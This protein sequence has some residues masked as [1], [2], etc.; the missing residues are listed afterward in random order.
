MASAESEHASVSLHAE[1]VGGINRTDVTFEQGVTVLVGRNATH[2]TSLLQ[3][4]MAGLGS[5]RASLKG[6]ADEGHVRLEVGDDIYTRTLKRQDGGTAF[7]DDPYL[8]DPELAD[9]FAFLLESNDA[10]RTVAL[11]GDLREII[12]EPVD[13]EAIEREIDRL[14]AE[15]RDTEERIAD[16]ESLQSELPSLE[17]EHSRLESKI[18]ETRERL[19]EKRDSLDE[20][21][22]DASDIEAE[23]SELE[24]KMADLRDR[25]SSLEQTEFRLDSQR[26]S[27][28]TLEAELADLQDQREDFSGAGGED[29]AAIRSEIDSLQERKRRLDSE[30]TKLQSVIQFNEEMMEGTSPD[31]ATALRGKESGAESVTDQLLET[32]ESVVCWTCGSEVEGEHIEQTLDRLRDLRESKYSEQSEVES[33]LE[34]LKARKSDVESEKRERERLEGKIDDVHSEIEEREGKIADLEAE[35]AE[36]RAAIEDLEAE[37]GNIEVPD[38]SDVLEAHKEVNELEIELDRLEDERD[39]VASNVEEIES[40]TGEIDE[41]EEHKAELQSRLTD[42]RTRI[43]QIEEQAVAEFNDHMETVLEILDYRNIDRIWVERAERE[44]RQ[45]RR[46]VEETTFDLHVVRSTGDGVTYEDSFG[47]LSESEREVTGLIFALAGYLAHEV[48]EEVP[49]MLLDSLEAIDSTRI[50]K[51]VEYM[52]EYVDYLVVALLPEDA[53][54]LNDSYCR[55]TD[56]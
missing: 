50:A 37:I 31:I 5:R 51:L 23:Q 56:I 24:A 53:A 28:D 33:R 3:A 8:D 27:I 22:A 34:K 26:E 49:F 43:D 41:L 25:R 54:A 4:V 7:E 1:N 15:K 10:R 48:Y 11:G 46:T 30:L 39:R 18:E 52:Q 12:M 6:D 32:N 44:V 20:R 35:R 16:L 47:H 45:G 19:E 29:L 55:I 38:R 13:A 21:S 17:K 14:K 9:L 2:R 40:R 36:L 42:L